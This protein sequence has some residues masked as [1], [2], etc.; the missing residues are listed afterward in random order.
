[1]VN[2]APSD[3]GGMDGGSSRTL[4]DL[5]DASRWVSGG[6]VN[7]TELVTYLFTIATLIYSEVLARTVSGLFALPR[8]GV[9]AVGDVYA[10]L[11]AEVVGFWP[12]V[13]TTSFDSAAAS[14]PDF[15]VVSFVVGIVFV[16]V[17]F[18]VINELL[19]VL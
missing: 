19:G 8:R 7:W 18:V 1:M 2:D 11:A 16:L 14:L 13:F 15:G 6:S 5:G 3:R 10:E 17:W 12:A 4:F 9:D